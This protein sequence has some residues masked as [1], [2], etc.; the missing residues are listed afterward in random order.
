MP[1]GGA[2]LW[3]RKA[4][5]LN[6]AKTTGASE[7][8]VNALVGEGKVTLVDSAPLFGGEKMGALSTYKTKATNW[9]RTKWSTGPK[10]M[11]VVVIVVG[12][13]ILIVVTI[14]SKVAGKLRR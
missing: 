3:A 4:E 5:V 2:G 10:G 13:A 1:R 8:Q 12:V 6:I 9:V 11:L 14:V 7:Q